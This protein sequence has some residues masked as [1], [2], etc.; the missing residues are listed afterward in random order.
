MITVVNILVV[1]LAVVVFIKFAIKA[2][3]NGK[4]AKKMRINQE[5][6]VKLLDEENAVLID[7]RTAEEYNDGHIK[8]SIN[9]PVMA[10]ATNASQFIPDK[11]KN[12][13]V[14]CLTGSRSSYASAVLKKAGYQNVYDFGAIANWK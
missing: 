10:V 1:I 4:G 2:Y 5:T 3:L 7:V 12:I 8:N 11:T 6:A 9:I 13:I 14:Y